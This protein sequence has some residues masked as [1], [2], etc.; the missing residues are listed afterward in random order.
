VP[1]GDAEA[2]ASALTVFLRDRAVGA[3]MGER[4]RETVLQRYG[5]GPV[6][7]AWMDAYATVLGERA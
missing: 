6:A 3:R 7:E 2:L 1:P 5:I 4:A